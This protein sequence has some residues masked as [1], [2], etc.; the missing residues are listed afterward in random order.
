M[1]GDRVPGS[2][3]RDVT[4]LHWGS[5]LIVHRYVASLKRRRLSPNT[6]RLRLV[7]LKQFAADQ[8]LLTAT[9]EQMEGFLDAHPLWSDNT[10]QSAIAS[11]RS[12][13]KWAYRS[14]VIGKNPAEDLIRVRV[15]RRRANIASEES[16]QAALEV[17]TLSEQAMV[18][19]G[20]ECGLRV[21]EIANLSIAS[22]DG[23]W[24]HIV[25]K[26]GHQRSL[27]MSAELTGIL[28]RL[29]IEVMRHGN[30][31]PG[32]SGT[33]MHP[34]T[35]WR[36]IRNIVEINPHALRHRAGTVVYK[37][38]GN[39][40][41]VTQEFLGHASPNT[42]RIYVHVERDDLVRASAASRIAA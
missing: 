13:Y 41:A 4:P 42:T 19:L 34:S 10:R 32:R 37:G 23:E 28:D 3:D 31:F 22:R 6:I 36:H 27:Y 9:L 14:E 1:M 24:L 39:D 16:I 5:E 7:Y 35:V 15:R 11:I 33:A 30:Y 29:E 26:G 17:G 8:D 2:G 20:A 38:T 18:L 40:L 25:G 21:S 12:F